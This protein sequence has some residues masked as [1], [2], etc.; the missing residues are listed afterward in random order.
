MIWLI[1][2]FFFCL[3]G[4]QVHGIWKFP[5]RGRT[6]ATAASR[7]HSHSNTISESRHL[8]HNSQQR[9]ILNPLSEARDRTQNLIEPGSP[10]GSL[11]LSYSRNFRLILFFSFFCRLILYILPFVA[12]SSFPKLWTI[13][14]NKLIMIWQ[15]KQDNSASFNYLLAFRHWT[16]MR[17]RYLSVLF[18]VVFPG[19]TAVP[20][21]W[22]LIDICWVHECSYYLFCLCFDWSCVFSKA[23]D[24]FFF[25]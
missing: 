7:L 15:H 19:L 3:L 24:A 22:Q 17:A 4:P 21:R 9:W 10:S 23:H 8:Q 13:F 14:V 20:Q 5:A 18:T 25:F 2:F 6:G 1:L 11:P 12:M 16:D